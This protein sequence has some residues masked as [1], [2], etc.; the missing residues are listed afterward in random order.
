M[1]EE[2]YSIEITEE[3]LV[4]Y[5]YL[6]RILDDKFYSGFIKLHE[7]RINDLRKI[8]NLA[9][10]A[11][12][13]GNRPFLI[14]RYVLDDLK[15]LLKKARVRCSDVAIKKENIKY[16]SLDDPMSKAVNLLVE[17]GYSCLPILDKNSRVIGAVTEK[18][19]VS[20]MHEKNGLF[21]YDENVTIGSE[22]DNFII[23]NNPREAF[24]FKS[25]NDLFEYVRREAEKLPRR[26]GGCFVTKKGGRNEPLEGLFTMWDVK[27]YL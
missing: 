9:V 26:F 22:I 2:I 21:T 15:D 6:D 13:Q 17:G 16:L 1:E 5:N 11:T 24:L 23:E 12:Y 7:D 8:R 19:L 10:H 4:Q 27:H 18:S 20:I 25:K 3:F 14:S